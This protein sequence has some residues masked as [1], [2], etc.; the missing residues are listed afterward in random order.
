MPLRHVKTRMIR[1]PETFWGGLLRASSCLLGPPARENTSP[2]HY[3]T[4]FQRL[5]TSPWVCV[6]VS[7]GL[8][9]VKTRVP[10]SIPSHFNGFSRRPAYLNVIPCIPASSTSAAPLHVFQRS[11]SS[12]GVT[13]SVWDPPRCS[14]QPHGVP[15]PLREA[16]LESEDSLL[17]ES[18]ALHTDAVSA[19]SLAA[20]AFSYDRANKATLMREITMAPNGT[21]RRETTADT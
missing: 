4:R 17:L 12:A 1:R 3:F 11:S 2:K 18:V 7:R 9:H 21:K 6:S 19:P 10:K 14:S 5:F 15:K 13:R 20:R 8:R 16:A